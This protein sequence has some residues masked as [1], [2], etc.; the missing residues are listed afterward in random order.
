MKIVMIHPHDI[1]SD[2]EPWTSRIRNIAR[3]LVRLGHEVRIVYFA[4]PGCEHHEP[5]EDVFMSFKLNRS[6]RASFKNIY[7]VTKHARWADII[8]FQKCFAHASVPAVCAHIFTNKPLHYD[9][10]DWE[11]QIYN[12]LR[13]SELVGKYIE[14]VE[15]SLPSFVDTITVASEGLRELAITLGFPAERIFKGHVCVDLELF[16]PVVD[17]KVIKEKFGITKPVV[18]YMGQLHGGQYA[19]LFIKTATQMMDQDVLFIIL[20]SGNRE[21]LLIQEAVESNLADRMI[22]VGAVAHEEIPQYLAVADVTVACFEDN[23]ITRHKSPLKVVE[24]MACGKAIVASDVGEV[25][26]MLNGC[27]VL[28]KPGDVGSLRDGILDLLHNEEKRKKL[29]KLARKNAEKNFA[30]SVT[31]KNM[32]EAYK[33]AMKLYVR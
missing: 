19:D 4:Y 3:E 31:A 26:S 15:N 30:W 33:M 25:K 18:M 11:I 27:G 29:E 5:Q 20:G 16:K 32:L 23:D 8:H 7:E 1:W 2:Q 28:A 12:F 9:W 6:R 21:Q 10:D 14:Y 17:G 22:F 24:Y 13:P